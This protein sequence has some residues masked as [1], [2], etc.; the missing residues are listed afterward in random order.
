MQ[1]IAPGQTVGEYP[2]LTLG[3]GWSLFNAKA[4]TTNVGGSMAYISA[5]DVRDGKFFAMLDMTANLNEANSSDW[6]D[7]PCKST[8][9]LYKK[10]EGFRNINCATVNYTTSYFVNPKGDFQ[11]Y[12]ARFRELKIEIPPTV[13]RIDFIRYSDRSRRLSYSVKL[14]PEAFGIERD[15]ETVWGANSWNKAFIERDPKKVALIAGLSK[16]ADA[17][18][19]KMD[20]AFD[21]KQ[22]AFDSLPS[23]DS[24]VKVPESVASAQ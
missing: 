14:N 17:V 23:F 24:F 13:V 19:D 20:K 15:P 22:D 2:I 9:F 8:H 6:T 7:E 1:K 4:G 21:H 16:W 5:I 11:T 18:R 3:N 12:L 10:G